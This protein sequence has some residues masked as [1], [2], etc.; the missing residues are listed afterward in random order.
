MLASNITWNK[1][2]VKGQAEIVE[3]LQEKAADLEC[4]KLCMGADKVQ[5]KVNHERFERFNEEQKRL[6]RDYIKEM[7]IKKGGL[8]VNLAGGASL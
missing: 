7:S 8:I 2:R 1:V 3:K 4:V 6:Q 5:R